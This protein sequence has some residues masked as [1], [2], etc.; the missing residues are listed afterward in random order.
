MSTHIHLQPGINIAILYL[1]SVPM[2]FNKEKTDITFISNL[3]IYTG[4][5]E[6]EINTWNRNHSTTLCTSRIQD[7]QTHEEVGTPMECWEVSAWTTWCHEQ[8]LLNWLQHRANF[9]SMNSSEKDTLKSEAYF[10]SISAV[11]RIKNQQNHFTGAWI[12]GLLLRA[13]F[14]RGLSEASTQILI[15][16]DSYWRYWSL[17][18]VK[19]KAERI[20]L[21]VKT[22]K[23]WKPPRSHR[24]LQGPE[25]RCNFSW[26]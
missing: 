21:R 22:L 4:Q 9:S 15:S 5:V 7:Q 24:P 12:F 10:L 23:M 16:A 17:E 19:F 25:T 3:H 13:G 1:L 26:S 20:H 11:R 2:R 18:L 8:A 14:V 6:L